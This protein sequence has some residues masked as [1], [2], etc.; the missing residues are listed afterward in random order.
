[1]LIGA[2]LLSAVLALTGCRSFAGQDIPV[3]VYGAL[4][5]KGFACVVTK[6]GNV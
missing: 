5:G 6:D 2:I 4:E 1:L 3:S